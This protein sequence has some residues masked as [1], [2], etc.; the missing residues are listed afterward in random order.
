M[1]SILPSELLETSG[2]HHV[3]YDGVCRAVM[4]CPS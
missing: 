3:T 2:L 1:G 4:M